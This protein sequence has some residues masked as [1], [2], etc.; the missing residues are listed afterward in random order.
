MTH[1]R[2]TVAIG[3]STSHASGTRT[4]ALITPRARQI[5]QTVLAMRRSRELQNRAS[6]TWAAPS[7][8]G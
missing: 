7:V 5:V 4:A 3:I 1:G 2:I 8:S 6:L